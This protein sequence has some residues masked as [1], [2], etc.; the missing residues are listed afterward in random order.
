MR[1][2]ILSA[3]LGA[4]IGAAGLSAAS[5]AP[6]NGLA[7]GDAVQTSSNIQDVYWRGRWHRG[8]RW[9]R[10]HYRHCYWRHHRRYCW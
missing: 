2:I 7:I 9:H 6:A 5:A 1:K 3:F 8:H 4:A 10:R